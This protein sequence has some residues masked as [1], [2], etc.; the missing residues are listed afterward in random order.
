MANICKIKNEVVVFSKGKYNFIKED[1]SSDVSIELPEKARRSIFR[2]GIIHRKT[3]AR[4]VI[5]ELHRYLKKYK[6]F[7]IFSTIADSPAI[8]TEND[9]KKL[10]NIFIKELKRVN[11]GKMDRM[12]LKAAK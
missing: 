4:I 2:K 10:F 3:N 9:L 7:Y 12:S 6:D 8:S 5:D 11:Y 1:L